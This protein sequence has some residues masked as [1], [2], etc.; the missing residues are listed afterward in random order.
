MPTTKHGSKTRIRHPKKPT[1]SQSDPELVCQRC[2]GLMVAIRLEDQGST[3]LREPLLGW[4]CLMCG[5]VL[6]PTIVANRQ[7]QQKPF[8]KRPSPRYGIMVRPGA[9]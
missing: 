8:A 3:T 5:N 7:A 6:D 2:H 9:D 1:H 4:R